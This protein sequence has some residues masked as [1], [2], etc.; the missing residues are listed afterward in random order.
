[1]INQYFKKT[2]ADILTTDYQYLKSQTFPTQFG[3]LLIDEIRVVE[4]NIGEYDILLISNADIPFREIYEVLNITNF[5]LVDYLKLNQKE[6]M[7]LDI[8]RYIEISFEQVYY[9]ENL[10]LAQ[11][12]CKY[13]SYLIED[14]CKFKPLGSEEYFIIDFIKPLKVG[15]DK[16]QIVVGR[17]TISQNVLES[18]KLLTQDIV[19]LLNTCGIQKYEEKHLKDFIE[20]YL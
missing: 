9:I 16:Y 3:D 7:P 19:T 11:E 2:L 10:N 4:I 13:Y 17:N 8:D 1:M 12:A 6:I 18:D 14:R 15:Q 5:R 20:L